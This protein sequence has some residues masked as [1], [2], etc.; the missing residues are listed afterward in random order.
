MLLIGFA[1]IATA[2]PYTLTNHGMKQVD[3]STAS[4][5]LLLDP[6]SSVI[7]GFI[8]IGQM[9]VFWQLIGASLIVC[10]TLLIALE[11]KSSTIIENTSNRREKKSCDI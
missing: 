1:L 3:A 2:I 4:I 9:V 8:L 10:A 11:Q 7:L 6:L 5:I